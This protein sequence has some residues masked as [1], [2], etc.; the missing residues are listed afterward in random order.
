M[1]LKVI[2]LTS[3]TCSDTTQELNQRRMTSLMEAK[4][5]DYE[6]CVCEEAVYFIS[7]HLILL[8]L[9][10]VWKRTRREE[11]NYLRYLKFAVSSTRL[12]TPLS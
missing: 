11:I 7:S 3:S 8:V 10:E 2:L 4:H 12:E 1:S 6:R 9:M 5:I